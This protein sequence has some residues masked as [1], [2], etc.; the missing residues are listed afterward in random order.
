MVTVS[1]ANCLPSRRVFTPT[2]LWMYHIG[3]VTW[4][5]FTITGYR[6]KYSPATDSWQMD[7]T[8]LVEVPIVSTE[9]DARACASDIIVAKRLHCGKHADRSQYGGDVATDTSVLQP[10]EDVNGN[11][12]LAG[13]LWAQLPLRRALPSQSFTLLCNFRVYGAARSVEIRTPKRSEFAS[14]KHA[15]AVGSLSGCVIP[16]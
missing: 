6:G 8:R 11:L 12:F 5:A 14:L 3:F 1:P 15:V 10:L 7:E 4:L 2:M 13:G 16:Q 9:R